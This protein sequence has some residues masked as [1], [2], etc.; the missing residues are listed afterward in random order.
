MKKILIRSFL[1]VVVLLILSVV[2]VVLFLDQIVKKGVETAG[3]MITQ[4]EVKLDHASISIL[5]GSAKLKGLFVGNPPGYKTDSAIKVG[6][7]SVSLKPKSI[8]SDKIIV[9]SVLIKSPEITLEGGLR[10]NNLTKILDNVN[11]T[12]A[13]DPGA[14]KPADKKTN[15]KIQVTDLVIS[16][17]KVHV[18]S[19]LLG[20]QSMTLTIPDIHLQ[21][22]GT[23]SD[24]LTPAEL[25]KKVMDAIVKEVIPAVVKA[26]SNL[27][28]GAGK[29]LGEEGKKGAE[30]ITGG[31]KGL[32]KK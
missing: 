26:A 27:G 8:F 30:K 13:K 22:L 32:F 19:S 11:G 18:S 6:D 14:E 9:E 10:E 28:Q 3:P 12:A 21:N 24:G 23:G 15:K 4:V 31:L 20:G 2:A 5:G 1:V 7:V 16:A 25:T 29:I 17:A